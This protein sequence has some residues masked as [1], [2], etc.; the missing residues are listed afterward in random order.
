MEVQILKG[1]SKVARVFLEFFS[2]S[3]DERKEAGEKT[4]EAFQK[5]YQWDKSGKVW[6][7]YFD[8]VDIIPHDQTWDSSPRIYMPQPKE[9]LPEDIDH[10][11]L[12]RWLVVNV[13]CEP[14]RVNTHFEARL[15]RDLLYQSATAT[16]GGMYFNESSSA[17]DGRNTRQPFN[18][19]IAYDHLKQLCERRNYW[20]QQRMAMS[21]AHQ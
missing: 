14:D 9:N 7:E 10:K 6:E 12:A 18:L 4:R 16:T 11:Q 13:L 15:T 17:F 1:L 5:H 2:K 8:S 20:E 19:D 3:A 21:P